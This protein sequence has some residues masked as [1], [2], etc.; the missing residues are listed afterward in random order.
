MNYLNI[1]WQKI[2]NNGIDEQVLGKSVINARLLNQLIFIGL[3]TSVLILITYLFTRKGQE[4]AIATFTNLVLEVIVIIIAYNRRHD[5]VRIIVCLVFPVVIAFHIITLGGDF[6]ETNIFTALAVTAFIVYES[7]KKYQMIVIVYI[8]LLFISSKLYVAQ[9]FDFVNVEVNPYDDIITFP[10]IIL[11]LG[12]IIIIYQ[13]ELK[14]YEVQQLVLINNLEKK[15]KKL[16]IVNEEL[17]QFTYIASHDL[18]TPLRTIN[19]HLDLIQHYIKRKRFDD[20]SESIGFAKKGAKQ[21]YALISD[22]LE[23]KMVSHQKEAFEI[24]DLNEVVANVLLG[25]ESVLVD[26]KAEVICNLLPKV[27]VRKSDF[28]ILFQNFIENGIKYNESETPIISIN[29]KQSKDRIIISFKDNGIGISDEYHEQIFKF[30]KRLHTQ[31]QYEGT[32]IGLGLCKKILLNYNGTIKLTSKEGDGSVFE[33]VMP[34]NI[35]VE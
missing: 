10:M 15:N 27:R 31:I 33:I 20:I 7:K 30:F 23:Y 14:K 24:I 11:V 6:G 25:L 9:Y 5:L 3:L 18:K 17:E 21:M 29:T 4:I 34:S 28:T 16:S 26:K 12:L 35:I 22:I 19:S 2:T 1:F 32:G 13:K 8:C